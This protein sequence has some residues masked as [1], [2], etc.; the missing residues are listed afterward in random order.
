MSIQLVI[1]ILCLIA[2]PLILLLPR[3]YKDKQ[4]VFAHRWVCED[5]VGNIL[6]RIYPD[7]EFIKVRPDFLKYPQ[8]GR[9]LELD[10]YCKDL[11]LCVE[12]NGKQH[13]KYVKFFHNS[14]PNKFEQQ[15]ARDAFK[16]KR[17][18]ELGITFIEI[19]YT[20][21]KDMLYNYVFTKI[22][23]SGG[24]ACDAL[25]PADS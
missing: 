6:K 1:L 2:I 13:Y 9:N 11:N 7:H 19:P 14:D 21:S 5:L 15:R 20:V 25:K 17:C 16:K 24:A 18:A 10:F 22:L 3:L 23:K 4:R 12:Y 8:T